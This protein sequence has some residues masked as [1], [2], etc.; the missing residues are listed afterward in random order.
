M[1][2]TSRAVKSE[3]SAEHKPKKRKRARLTPQAIVAAA[4]ELFA[5][6]GFGAT[7]LN[8]IANALGVTKVALYY[9][10]NSKEEILRLIYLLVL[11]TAE[12]PLRRIIESDLPSAEKL[13]RAIEHHITLTANASPMITVFYH[14]QSHLTGEFAREIALREKEYERYFTRI[15]QEGIEKGVF[16]PE[17]DPQII[18]FGLLGMC[19]WLSQWY[20]PSGRYTPQQIANMFL[21][22]VEGGLLKSATPFHPTRNGD[23]TTFQ[24]D[25]E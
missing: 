4:A 11:E 3:K 1:V 25:G 13:G 7:S 14:E 24:D 21:A 20:K 18:T 17:L 5:R 9:H 16:K 19:H 23:R 8:D 6:D 2:N 15:I 10:V 12:E 22:M